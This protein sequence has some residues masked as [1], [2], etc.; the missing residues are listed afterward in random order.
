MKKEKQKKRILLIIIL[1][2]I[3][4][5]LSVGGYVWYLPSYKMVDRTKQMKETAK[6]YQ[7]KVLGW[8]RVE[9]T[10]IDLPVIYPGS[11]TNVE[12]SDYEFAWNHT[13]STDIANKN[14]IVSHNIRNVSRNPLIQNEKFTRFDQL[15]A[16]LYFD[17]AKENQFI[18]YT[19]V[20]GKNYLYRI[21]S[22]SMVKDS[23][24]D[25]FSRQISRA[26]MKKY[27][28][29]SLKESY[30]KYDT[31]I[32]END[33]ILSLV[34]CTRF[35]GTLEKIDIRIDA[36]RVHFMERVQPVK[37]TKRENYQEVTERMEM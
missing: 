29:K 33:T 4:V 19:S 32:D 34:T 25:Y 13:T 5:L 28:A 16:F 24:I 3:A 9:G 26:N 18:Q 7:D 6:K 21:F 20:D 15:P 8:V 37:V 2:G 17:F 10:D 12:K 27:I 31:S 35:F 1:I 23:E 14:V 22:V 36:R 30:Y 11:A